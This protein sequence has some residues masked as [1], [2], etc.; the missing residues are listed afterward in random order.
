MG[1]EALKRAEPAPLHEKAFWSI[2]DASRGTTLSARQ[3]LKMI[4]EGR[5]TSVRIGR[6]ILLDPARLKR[7]LS[8]LGGK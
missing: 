2:S 3:L 6:R 4:R 8:S 5:I 7:E 1:V